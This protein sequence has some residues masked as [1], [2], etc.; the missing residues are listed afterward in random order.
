MC[1]AL[2]DFDFK[3]LDPETFTRNPKLEIICGRCGKIRE[4][5][6][7]VKAHPEKL[8]PSNP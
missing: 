3:L 4:I 2:F 1:G 5:Q 8:I 7:W 6:I